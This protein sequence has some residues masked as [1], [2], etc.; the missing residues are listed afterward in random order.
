MKSPKIAAVVAMAAAFLC[1]LSSA[2]AGV[3]AKFDRFKR[4][5]VVSLEPDRGKIDGTIQLFAY[6][7]IGPGP[8]KQYLSTVV[9][10][11]SVNRN[12]RYLDCYSTRWL[13]DGALVQMPLAQHG[14]S[15]SGT[16][17]IEHVYSEGGR[18][19]RRPPNQ[20]WSIGAAHGDQILQAHA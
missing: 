11:N 13:A 7:S 6:A 3:T 4:V 2:Q 18:A 8:E 19:G 15:V 5:T 12:W 20:V 1:C 14:G 9:L 10:L 16:F 17:V